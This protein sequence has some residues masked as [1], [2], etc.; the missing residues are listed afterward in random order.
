MARTE[1]S[2]CP[3]AELECYMERTGINQNDKCFLFQA[4]QNNK[5]GEV[6]RQ[7]KISYTCMNELY[8][9]KLG[10]DALNF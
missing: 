2:T 6:L 9:K 1:T 5:N 7:F 3:V 10:E 8:D 4:I